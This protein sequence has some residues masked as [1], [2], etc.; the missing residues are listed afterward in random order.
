MYDLNTDGLILSISD[1]G[2]HD[3]CVPYT[4]S[5]AWTRSVGYK[6]VDEWRPWICNEQVAGWVFCSLKYQLY[7]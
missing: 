4:G 6:L 7:L 2:D 5:E 3:M 1:S